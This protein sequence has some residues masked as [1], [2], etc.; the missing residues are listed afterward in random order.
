MV[1]TVLDSHIETGLRSNKKSSYMFSQNIYSITVTGEDGEYFTCEVMA[2]TSADACSVA[3]DLARDVMAD[4][5]Y[6]T[7]NFMN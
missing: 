5:S 4:I 2:D 6:I 1:H 7:V 3:E